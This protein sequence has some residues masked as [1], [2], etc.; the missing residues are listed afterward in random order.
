MNQ[1]LK[2]F[3]RFLSIALA[4]FFVISTSLALVLYNL[5]REAFSPA[6]YEQILSEH[7]VYERVPALL[8]ETMVIAIN[9]DPCKENP[10]ACAA[11]NASPELENCLIETLGED[12]YTAISSYERPPTEAEL[13]RTASCLQDY[14]EYEPSQ[15]GPP[16]FLQNLTANDWEIIFSTLLPPEATRLLIHQT[17][18]QTLAYLNGQRESVQINLRPVKARL[19]GPA[20]VEAFLQLLA[21]QPACSPEQIARLIAIGTGMDSGEDFTLCN[22]PPQMLNAAM[23]VLQEQVS[24]F[25]SEIPD[26]ITILPQEPGAGAPK[27]L[28]S[29]RLIMRLSPLMPMGI[30]LGITLL[31]VRT[32]RTWLRWWGIPLLIA[33]LLGAILGWLLTPLFDLIFIAFVT[34]NLPP[35][36]P[37]NVIEL[38]YDV[39]AGV[40]QSILE[41][42]VLQAIAIAAIGLLAVIGSLFAREE[43]EEPPSL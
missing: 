33:G 10:I 16:P 27:G 12:A 3:W 43:A 4:F 1:R 29:L 18:I 34:T 36:F 9:Y 40:V 26:E 31:A 7:N 30:L 21:A 2:G 32:L 41:P 42:V 8:A 20:G 15:E 24:A 39:T 23:P 17:L 19:G 11:E 35:F 28:R 6:R 37:G 5:E 13:R 22:P 38:I 25:A 14:S